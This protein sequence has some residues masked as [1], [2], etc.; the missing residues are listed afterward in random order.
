VGFHG[1]LGLVSLVHD[2]LTCWT[3]AS[4]SHCAGVAHGSLTHGWPDGALAQGDPGCHPTL[5]AE[6]ISVSVVA[7]AAPESN[8]SFLKFFYF[9]CFIDTSAAVTH[10]HLPIPTPLVHNPCTMS[11]QSNDTGGI[12]P[13]PTTTTMSAK[14]QIAE[15]MG[16]PLT[17]PSQQYEGIPPWSPASPDYDPNLH[18]IP[19]WLRPHFIATGELPIPVPTPPDQPIRT[20][21]TLLIE[22]QTYEAMLPWVLDRIANGEAL[23]KILREDPRAHNISVGTFNRWL[24]KDPDRL[25]QY[26][27]AQCSSAEV[28]VGQMDEVMEKAATGLIDMEGAKMFMNHGK[29][30]V[31]KYNS[32]RYGDKVTADVT[33]GISVMAALTAGNSRMLSKPSDEELGIIDVDSK[34]VD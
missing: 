25:R 3:G 26:E 11:I 5:G 22:H 8:F 30:K 1:L 19:K 12:E 24:R 32:G 31:S 18:H 34:D 23:T 21:N 20:T 13:I 4:L 9:P 14:R 15:A 29:W 6:V 17:S 27:E 33:M 16:L 10:A 28:T 2:L 7:Q